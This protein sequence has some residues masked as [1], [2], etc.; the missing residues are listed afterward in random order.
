MDISHSRLSIPL[1]MDVWVVSRFG[2][3]KIKLLCTF[4]YKS[5]TDICFCFYWMGLMGHRADLFNVISNSQTISKISKLGHFTL[6]LA[7]Y[8]SFSCSTSLPT[9]S[10]YQW[11]NCIQSNGYI[12]VSYCDFTWSF[13]D[14]YWCWALFHFLEWPS[15]YFPLWSVCVCIFPFWLSYLYFY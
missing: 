4:L 9:F 3:L 14:D 7:I 10:V 1:L 2:L 5:F 11:L 12:V 8:E 13:L 6:P 15:V